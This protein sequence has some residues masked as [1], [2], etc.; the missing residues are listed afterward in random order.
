MTASTHLHITTWV[1]TL[2]LFFVAL[3]LHKS[4]KAKAQKIVHMILRLFYLLTIA[5]GGMIAHLMF[6][7]YPITY[8]LKFIFGFLVIGFMEM[9]LVR[10]KKEKKTTMFW[11]LFFVSL[12]V[13]LV[14]GF[15]LP[16][17]F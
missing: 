10:T 9:V 7:Q 8:V 14:L 12:I 15:Y 16:L 1:L 4:G 6:S 11:V 5:T 13:V 3:G 2:I 17:S